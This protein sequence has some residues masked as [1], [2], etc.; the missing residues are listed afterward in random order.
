MFNENQLVYFTTDADI[1]HYISPI[2]AVYHDNIP[3]R[4]IKQP[5]DG[6]LSHTRVHL[7]YKEWNT[8]YTIPNKNLKLKPNLTEDE[9]YLEKL[10]R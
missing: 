6:T 8:K 3:M 5:S 7:K 9:Q 10:L 1:S 4:V 2:Q